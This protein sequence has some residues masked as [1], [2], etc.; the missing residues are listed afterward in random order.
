M[1]K[2]NYDYCKAAPMLEWFGSKWLFVVLLKIEESGT[3]RFN[4]LY[5]QIPS[6]S[7]KVLAGVLDILER[8]GLVERKLY[9]EV[10]PRTEYRITAFASTLM[11]HVHALVG[12]GKDNFDV[13]MKNRGKR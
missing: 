10:P 11:P 9:A 7:M 8:D 1:K 13:I 12:W 4:E 2:I 6:V 5:R 3:A